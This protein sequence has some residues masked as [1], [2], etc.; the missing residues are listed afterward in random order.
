MI[1]RLHADEIECRVAQCGKSQK[2]AWCS[3]LLYKDARVDQRILDEVYGPMNWQRTHQLIGDRLYCTVS[4]W[5]P[6]KCEWISKQD[7]GTESNTEK[8]KGQASDAFKRACFNVGIGRELYTA[9][10]IFISL[11]EGEYT[12]KGD[13]IYPKIGLDVKSISYDDKGNITDLSLSDN[14]GAIRYQ[15]P[16]TSQKDAGWSQPEKLPKTPKTAYSAPLPPE[17]KKVLKPGTKGWEHAVERVAKG[18]PG[19]MDKIR[20]N[21]EWDEQAEADFADA[22]FNYNIDNRDDN[23]KLKTA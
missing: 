4:I 23:G 22:V 10:K 19:L 7:V 21:Y 17:R 6:S 20:E 3:I 13:K 12:E 2:G 14:S 15:F 8:E 16:D 5:D 18:E 9:P 1:R 11:K